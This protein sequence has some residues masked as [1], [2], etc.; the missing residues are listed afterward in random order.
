M[1]YLPLGLNVQGKKC[2][3]VGGGKIGT[4]KVENLLRA[5]A[6]VHLVAPEA[7]ER[8]REL[9][10][11][12]RI[13]WIREAAGA[14]H[15]DGALLAV[16]ATDDVEENARLTKTA[17]GLGVLICDASSAERSEIIFGA[18]HVAEGLTIAVFTDGEDPTRA[19]ATRDGIAAFVSK[20]RGPER[21]VDD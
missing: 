4:R 3:V 17:K 1:K 9:A 21:P 7:S 14:R 18:L 10:E 8:A 19:R 2:V 12:G 15:F 5:G 13:T 6:A 20:G 11:R 16:A